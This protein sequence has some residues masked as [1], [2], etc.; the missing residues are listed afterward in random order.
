M[1][2][3]Y[4]P[5][6]SARQFLPGKSHRGG[7]ATLSSEAP[8][9]NY[10]LSHNSGPPPHPSLHI[11]TTPPSVFSILYVISWLFMSPCCPKTTANKNTDVE[12]LFQFLVSSYHFLRK[13]ESLAKADWKSPPCRCF[14]DLINLR[15]EGSGEWW[16][17]PGE[18]ECL[19]SKS[20]PPLPR[21]RPSDSW[22]H[23][24]FLSSD[25]WGKG[26][27]PSFNYPETS[28]FP[29][30]LRVEEL[31]P[32]PKITPLPS[33]VIPQRVPFCCPWFL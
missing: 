23:L 17:L 19:R 15:W 21:S 28:H 31:F 6:T 12:I 18:L 16:D 11:H 33:R 25:L 9:C 3:S 7:P 10:C 22:N 5:G 26:Q 8:L 4:I 24:H 2:N 20:C 27:N 14:R 29:T 32:Q 30:G 1:G 13:T